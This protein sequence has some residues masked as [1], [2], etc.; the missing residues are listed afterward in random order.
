MNEWWMI[1]TTSN[2]GITLLASPD[3]CDCCV[4]AGRSMS[5]CKRMLPTIEAVVLPS[6]GARALL[7]AWFAR[8][9]NAAGGRSG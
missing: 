9:D 2:A 4:M 8:S 5:G 7:C 3:I 1:S 6:A